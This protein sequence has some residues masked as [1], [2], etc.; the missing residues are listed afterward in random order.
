VRYH[1]DT[2]WLRTPQSPELQLVDDGLD[3]DTCTRS[4][5][6]VDQMLFSIPVSRGQTSFTSVEALGHLHG[7][8]M[9]HA[10]LVGSEFFD[11]K[12]YTEARYSYAT[13]TTDL[14]SP[15]HRSVP[16]YLLGN[17]DWAYATRTSERWTSAY[18]QDQI[19]IGGQVYLLLGIRYDHAREWLDV[20]SGVPLQD[21]GSDKRWDHA[22]RRHAGVVWRAAAPLSLYANYAENF[23]ISLGIYGDGS[24]GTGTL[25][26]AETAYEWEVGAKAEFLDG[27]VLG[28]LAWFDL[29]ELNISLPD[30]LG[31]LNA[32]GTRKVTGAERSRGVELDIRGQVLPTVQLSASYAYLDARVVSDTGTAVDSDGNVISTPGNTGNRLFGAP[33]H[34]GSAWVTFTPAGALQGLKIGAGAIARGSREGDSANDY[35]LPGFVRYALLA[36]Y[37]WPWEKGRLTAQLNVDNVFNTRNFESISGTYTVMPGAPRRWLASLRWTADPRR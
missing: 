14:Y 1:L 9:Q 19:D 35:T 11:V 16:G 6:P 15:I 4:A 25:V 30:F 7:L 3:P 23:G 27:R 26:P 20:L 31:T 29:N 22:F 2:R 18:A 21:S 24:G 13:F 32:I 17:P 37:E 34:G 36:A 10:I 5:C 28:S 12:G 8:G 33:R